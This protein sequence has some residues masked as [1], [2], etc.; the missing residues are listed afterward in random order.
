MGRTV[1]VTGASG[2]VGGAL[3]RALDA[4]GYDVRALTRNPER[5]EGAGEAVH[6]DLAD[7]STLGKA[8]KGVDAAY[9]LVHS[10]SSAHF[11]DDDAG[12]ARAFAVAAATAGVRQIVYLSGLG[13]DDDKLSPHL[14]SRREVEGLLE[15]TGVPVTVL[16]AAIVVGHGGVSW[17]MTRRL[18][19]ALPALMT[20]R[21]AS[22]RTQPISLDDTVAYLVGVLGQKNA[23]G[24]TF[25]IGGA[26]VLTYEQ[27]LRRCAQ[28][29]NGRGVTTVQLPV[30]GNP[31]TD[32]LTAELSSRGLALLTGV[33]QE[34]AKNLI[35]SMGNEVVVSDH[36]IR[37]VVPLEPMGY[38]EMVRTAL[39]DRLRA[40]ERL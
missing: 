30:P 2:F 15:G 12:A 16:R 20:P 3:A 38:D 24:R 7:P 37:D 34:T 1:L 10:L 35:A 6:G 33:N 18:A 22:T 4:E 28:I 21:W 13:S 17:E 39:S 27:M 11:E 9:Y 25:E 23:L 19:R 29:Q 8:F 36:S 31:L 26:E 40:G 14:R 5:Y 32:A